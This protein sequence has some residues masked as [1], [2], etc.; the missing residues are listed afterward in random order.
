MV[1]NHKE[2]RRFEEYFYSIRCEAGSVVTTCDHCRYSSIIGLNFSHLDI[3]FLRRKV[4]FGE[5]RF[6]LGSLS[7]EVFEKIG[8]F[9]FFIIRREGIVESV[10]KCNLTISQSVVMGIVTILLNPEA[11]KSCGISC[12]GKMPGSVAPIWSVCNMQLCD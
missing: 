10:G 4:P 5:K 12:F 6:E 7:A 2:D 8:I 9:F 1:K 11:C 3:F